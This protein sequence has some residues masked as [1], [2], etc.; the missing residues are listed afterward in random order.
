MP[1]ITPTFANDLFKL[2]FLGT[3]IANIADN[4]ASS[5]NAFA[6]WRTGFRSYCLCRSL[7]CCRYCSRG[8]LRG[9]WVVSVR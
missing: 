8:G 6:V 7:H 2:M 3:P 9:A 4:A 1:G 5:P